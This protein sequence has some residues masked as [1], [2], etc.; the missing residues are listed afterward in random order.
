MNVHGSNGSYNFPL[1]M[2]TWIAFLFTHAMLV[3]L[4]TL[5]YRPSSHQEVISLLSE[6]C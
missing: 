2:K 6:G 5:G 1:P 4:H 3:Q